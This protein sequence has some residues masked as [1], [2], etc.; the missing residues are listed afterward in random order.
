MN[1]LR[2]ARNE[3]LWCENIFFLLLSGFRLL[4]FVRWEAEESKDHPAVRDELFFEMFPWFVS[5]R[6]FLHSLIK[7]IFYLKIL[8]KSTPHSKI[9]SDHG[10]FR[11]FHCLSLCFFLFK[12][13][14]KCSTHK[15][16]KR[17]TL[18]DFSSF[19]QLCGIILSCLIQFENPNNSLINS[20]FILNS[21]SFCIFFSWK[22]LS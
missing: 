14:F 11:V 21:H 18:P 20:F 6:T 8:F 4:L 19:N 17:K 5:P 9:S 2:T 3:K 22:K 13:K 16:K 12:F 15:S 1:D 10:P 7:S